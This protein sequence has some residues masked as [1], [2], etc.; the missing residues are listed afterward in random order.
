MVLFC[1]RCGNMLFARVGEAADEEGY[2][3]GA[4]DTEASLEWGGRGTRTAM[5]CPTCPYRYSIRSEY[6]RKVTLPERK[7]RADVLGGEEQ[8]KNAD[9]TNEKCEACGNC[10][11]YY[12]QLQIRSGD[13][14]ATTFYCCTKCMAR[15]SS[16]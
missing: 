15:W 5:G 7:T 16:E 12:M 3:P 9:K 4:V 14:P 10:E 1:P 13:E 2:A 8:W 6:R 11:A